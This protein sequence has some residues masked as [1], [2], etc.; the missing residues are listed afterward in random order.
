M[1]KYFDKLIKIKF[2]ILHYPSH[3]NVKNNAIFGHANFI[4][5]H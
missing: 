5:Y 2:Y 4:G 3:G 1:T